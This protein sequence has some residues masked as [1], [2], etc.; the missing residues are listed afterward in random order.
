MIHG[1][2]A[3]PARIHPHSIAGSVFNQNFDLIEKFYLNYSDI[4]VDIGNRL[5]T[6]PISRLYI[7][8]IVRVFY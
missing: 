1:S 6:I 2:L 3:P 4:K 7:F 5:T 8:F